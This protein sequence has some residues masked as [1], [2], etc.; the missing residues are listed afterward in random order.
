MP[1]PDVCVSLFHSFSVWM[2]HRLIIYF[3]QHPNYSIVHSFLVFSYSA[4][5]FMHVSLASVEDRN[6]A[7]DWNKKWHPFYSKVYGNRDKQIWQEERGR[8]LSHPKNKRRKKQKERETISKIYSVF[9]K[10]MSPSKSETA[11]DRDEW[12]LKKVS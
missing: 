3:F 6:I 2:F 4:S 7:Q 11:R 12:E 1:E 8:S 10:W 5:H 9:H